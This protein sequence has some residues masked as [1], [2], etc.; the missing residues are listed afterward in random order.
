MSVSYTID[1]SGTIQEPTTYPEN[2]SIEN[3]IHLFS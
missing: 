2:Y 1:Y 3:E